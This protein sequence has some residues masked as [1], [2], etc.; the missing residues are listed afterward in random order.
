MAF[1]TDDGDY[2]PGTK[3]IQAFPPA[4]RNALPLCHAN[5]EGGAGTCGKAAVQLLSIAA[6][7]KVVLVREGLP[8][9]LPAL[10]AQTVQDPTMIRIV[11]L[12][13][14]QHKVC[15]EL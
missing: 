5:I 2:I 6:H 13:P 15:A 1:L 4:H 7:N 10:Y 8:R 3:S 11:E 14:F 12:G 9:V